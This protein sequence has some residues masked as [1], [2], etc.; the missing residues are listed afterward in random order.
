MCGICGIIQPQGKQVERDQLSKMNML[1]THRGP[2]SDGFYVDS[3]VGLAMRR[4]KIIDL[5]TG[6]QPICNEDGSIWIIYNG[7][8][9]NYQEIRSQLIRKGHSFKTQSD[10]ECILHLYEEKGIEALQELRGMFAIALWDKKRD[11]LLLARD[12]FGKKPLYYS[13]QHNALY[14]SSELPSLLAG[15]PEKPDIDICSIDLYLAFQYIPE[16]FTPYRGMYK[17]PSAHYLTWKNN[18]PSIEKYW[19]LSYTPKHQEKE[20]D[21]MAQLREQVQEAVRLRMVSEVPL[22][23]HLSG[24]ID[25]SIIVY[26]MAKASNQPVKTFSVGFKEA[27]FSELEYARQV[28]GLVSA[29]HTEFFL[30]YQDVRST[31]ERIIS[32]M[33]EPFGDPSA[34]PLYLLSELTRQ[35]V[36]V[37]LNGD[38]GDESFAGYQ[39]YWLDP[40]ANIYSK[41]PATVTQ[42][43]LPALVG[44]LPKTYDKPVGA[45]LG[46]GLQRLKQVAKSNPKASMLRWS[47]YF[48]TEQRKALWKDSFANALQL[49]LPEQILSELFDNAQAETFLD[50]TLST[51]IRS[52]LPGDLLVKA[53]RMTMA[54]SLEGRSPFLDHK[55]ASWVARLPVKYKT[56]FFSGKY[57][58]RKAYQNVLPQAIMKRTKQ[59]FGIPVSRWF[60]EDLYAWARETLLNSGGLFGLWFKQDAIALMLDEHHN[61]KADHGKRIWNLMA[62]F[63][64]ASEIKKA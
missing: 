62:L 30:E 35:H 3:H 40:F 24:G 25:S 38:G 9:Y 29:E 12:R 34:I 52:Y 50:R 11:L 15:L 13:I 64:W 56:R 37:A 19:E 39:R 21:L 22:G 54:H 49:D 6:D 33:G 28:A 63:I 7:E 60:R 23:A 16:P 48:S 41:M 18:Q 1:L 10:T 27:D 31:L 17:V 61:Q 55:L 51:D 42:K 32:M 20:V 5:A 58:L 57:L 14:F 2:D 26:E 47:S 45:A 8:I 53:D 36:T 59:G 46:D 43:A 4:L 44:F